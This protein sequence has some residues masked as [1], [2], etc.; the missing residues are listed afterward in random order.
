[1]ASDIVVNIGSGNG[2]VPNRCQAITWTN[3]DFLTADI[4]MTYDVCF[5]AFVSALVLI[6]AWHLPGAKPLSKT[7]A[8]YPF[9]HF[10]RYIMTSQHT[11]ESTRQFFKKND[12]FGLNPDNLILFEQNMLPCMTF[13]GKIILEK[14]Y[15][16]ARAPGRLIM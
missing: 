12:Y 1:M 13:E 6:M 2:M 14:P 5:S 7:N 10:F 3:A 15:K 16:V 11:K 8:D 4:I 9:C